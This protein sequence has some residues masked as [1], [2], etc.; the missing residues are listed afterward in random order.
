MRFVPSTILGMAV[1]TL[2]LSSGVASA[3]T[4]QCDIVND[5]TRTNGGTVTTTSTSFTSVPGTAVA[6]TQSSNNCLIVEFSAQ[7]NTQSAIELRLT[8]D[9]IP[10]GFPALANVLGGNGS[11]NRTIRFVVPPDVANVGQHVYALDFRSENG[12][13]ASMSRLMTTVYFPQ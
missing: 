3:A 2:I 13:A 11:D 1:A 6:V 12:Q 9:G 4:Y 7:I 5:R 10:V 8:R